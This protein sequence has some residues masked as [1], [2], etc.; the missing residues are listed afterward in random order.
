[1][2]L[3][4]CLATCT[5]AHPSRSR[6]HEMV[7]EVQGEME[8]LPMDFRLAYHM[9][10]YDCPPWCWRTLGTKAMRRE[11]PGSGLFTTHPP[12]LE[13]HLPT[14]I[15]YCWLAGENKLINPLGD[16]ETCADRKLTWLW[17]SGGNTDQKPRQVPITLQIL[18]SVQKGS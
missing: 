8:E 6:S 18:S 4:I 3:S 17:F 1:M 16:W 12:D 7:S 10:F 5:R 14:L 9:S 2:R 11:P 15:W 13:S